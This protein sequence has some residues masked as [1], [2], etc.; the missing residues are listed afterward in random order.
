MRRWSLWGVSMSAA[1]AFLLAGWSMAAAAQGIGR[2][3]EPFYNAARA[4]FKSG[5]YRNALRMTSHAAIEAPKSAKIHELASLALMALGD[6]R[7]AA[8]E[9]HAAMVFG[10]VGDWISLVAYY[11]NAN[12]YTKQLR[13]LEAY[14]KA[15]PAAAAGRFLLAYQYLMIGSPA[16][17]KIQMRE[18]VKLAPKDRLA[19][20]VLKQLEAGR[21]VT[22]P[23]PPAKK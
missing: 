1:L 23:P 11:D 7:A 15:H 3:A 20:Y 9:A 18:A 6:Y 4:A 2:R 10:P 16:E 12:T 5:D 14:V 22:P 13:A 21:R 19:A 8:I 17:A